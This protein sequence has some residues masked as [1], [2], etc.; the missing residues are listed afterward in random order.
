MPDWSKIP[1][2]KEP[3]K[4]GKAVSTAY[5]PPWNRMNGTG[6]T[7][8]GTD[9][10][11]N[12]Q[13]YIVAVDPRIIPLGTRVWIQPNPFNHN[14]PFLADDTGGAIKGNRIDFYDWRGRARQL[15]WGR[16][17]VFVAFSGPK[18]GETIEEIADSVNDPGVDVGAPIKAV[19]N[20]VDD[21]AGTAGQVLSWLT[22]SENWIRVAKIGGGF[23][24]IGLAGSYILKSVAASQVSSVVKSA[25]KG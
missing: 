12:K 10:R 19:A 16:R 6:V 15:A 18:A 25:V 11:P 4:A 17:K 23:V 9:L 20:A 22:E 7:A 3:G 1:D 24:M 13:A 5:G 8:G 21:L 2:L 14:G